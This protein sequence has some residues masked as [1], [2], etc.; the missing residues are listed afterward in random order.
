MAPARGHGAAFGPWQR[1]EGEFPPR[2][3]PFNVTLR[4]CHVRLA[5]RDPAR[6]PARRAV[7]AV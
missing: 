2:A 3:Q 1:R 7:A 6:A 5:R 4:E